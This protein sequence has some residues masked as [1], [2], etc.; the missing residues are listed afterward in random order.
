MITPR[1]LRDG[2]RNGEWTSAGCRTP[3][4]PPEWPEWRRERL[5]VAIRAAKLFLVHKNSYVEIRTKLR[6]DRQIKAGVSRARI[7]QYIDNGMGFLLDRGAFT[8]V[9]A[10]KDRP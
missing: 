2:L 4:P 8:E 3:E 7:G 10:H 6:A 5:R 9:L 1:K